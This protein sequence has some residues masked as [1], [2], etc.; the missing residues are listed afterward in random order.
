MTTAALLLPAILHCA[1]RRGDA[2]GR[3]AAVL[4]AAAWLFGEN[5]YALAAAAAAILALQG[6]HRLKPAEAG[7]VSLGAWGLAT[8]AAVWRIATTLE[9][10]EVH[11]LNA[12]LP[13]WIRRAMSAARDGALAAA[14]ALSAWL[15]CRPAARAGALTVLPLAAATAV[16]A[17][18]CVALTPR[19]FEAWTAREF[20]PRQAELFGEMRAKIP[21]E[22]QVFWPESPLGTW[23]LLERPSYLSVI[24][25]SGM[26]FS[27]PSA[28]EL[29]RR[30]TALAQYIGPATFMNWSA[31][32]TGLN[33]SREQL[34]GICSTGAFDF[35]VTAADL[36]EE[37]AVSVAVPVRPSAT[38]GTAGRGAA[39]HR[40]KLY[41][42]RP[43]AG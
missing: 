16:A 7:W 31:A 2:S 4:L 42:C 25:T 43:A 5:P 14:L 24:Q 6:L 30:A 41:R 29:E 40:T 12:D 39:A 33:L 38:R 8:I 23:M 26:V 35:L 15:G 17:V 20:P 34:A 9:F 18:A 11:Y 37:P 32:G 21:L 3:T 22:A 28:R 13:L 19:T 1:W 36:D 10:T 27:R